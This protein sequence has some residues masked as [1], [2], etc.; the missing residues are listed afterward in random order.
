MQ[1]VGSKFKEVAV[2]LCSVFI[3]FKWII[4]LSFVPPSS[5]KILTNFKMPIKITGELER[6]ESTGFAKRVVRGRHARRKKYAA[7]R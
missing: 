4:I 5:N 3:N 1:S 2:S 6:L 7:T